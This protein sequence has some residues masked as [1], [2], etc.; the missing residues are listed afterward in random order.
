MAT[1]LITRDDTVALAQKLGKRA[2]QALGRLRAQEGESVMALSPMATM[3]FVLIADAETPTGA[4]DLIGRLS[5][6]LGRPVTP[7]TVY[8]AIEQ[9]TEQ[10]LVARL[11]SRN[12]FVACAHPGHRHD[13][14]LLVCD[15]CGRAAE[16]EDE[17]LDRLILADAKRSG[18]TPRHRTLEVEGT[19]RDCSGPREGRG[20]P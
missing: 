14:V 6:L 4:Y 9:L 18:F 8:R 15:R 19:C 3:V 11:A 1:R 5:Q 7:P 17:K 2:Q 12:A 10:R 16:V 13:C 20:K